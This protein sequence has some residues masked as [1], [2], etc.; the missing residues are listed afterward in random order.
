MNRNDIYFYPATPKTIHKYASSIFEPI[1]RHECVSTVWVP[2]SGRRRWNRFII[3]NIDLFERELP[4]YKN[5]FFVYVEPLDLTEETAV[6]Y[7]KLMIRSLV[8][9]AEK[10]GQEITNK[11]QIVSL[12][13]DSTASYHDLL[14]FLRVFI[15]DLALKG[16]EVVFLFGEF[17]EL[18]FANKLFYNNLKSLWSK[19]YPNLHYIF[20]MITVPEN[21]ENIYAWDELSELILQNVVYVPLRT[22][23]EIDYLINVFASEFKFEIDE[24]LKIVLKQVCGGHPYSLRIAARVLKNS[25]NKSEKVIRSLLLDHYELKSI[26]IGIF[27]RRSF[28]EKNV[29]ESIVAKNKISEEDFICVYSLIKLGLVI[30]TSKGYELFSELFTRAILNS[31]KNKNNSIKTPILSLDPVSGAVLLNGFT[32]E[33]SFTRQEYTILSLFLKNPGKLLTRE[34]LGL[35]LWGDSHYEKYSD[36]AIDQVMSKL[37]KKLKNIGVNAKIITLRGRGYKFDTSS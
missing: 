32:V 11:N 15:L 16:F 29:L 10:H 14:E 17:D 33:E 9:V 31:L 36:W 2:M 35:E 13:N 34:I 21:Q 23:T 19:L 20:L 5:Y 6:G 22:D 8:D 24:N 30:E 27:D 3:E 12:V 4:S 1:Q 37:R 25:L 28:K 18:K 26:A 7:L